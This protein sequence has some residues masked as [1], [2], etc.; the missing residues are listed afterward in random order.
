MNASDIFIGNKY[1]STIY[2]DDV[3]I[4]PKEV[5]PAENKVIAD[6]IDKNINH[7]LENMCYEL[8]KFG[9]YFELVPGQVLNTKIDWKQYYNRCKEM[10]DPSLAV[11]MIRDMP[12]VK[13]VEMFP[14]AYDMGQ[15][16]SRADALWFFEVLEKKVTGE[17]TIEWK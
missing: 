9:M 10:D 7:P 12:E 3:V 1:A 15:Y 17:N 4:T 6:C 11:F 16:C 5:I 14:L 2:G 8:D 13:Y